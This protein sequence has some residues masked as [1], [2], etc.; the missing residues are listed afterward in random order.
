MKPLLLSIALLFSMPAWARRSE[1]WDQ[2]E[3]AENSW[4]DGGGGS[5][6]IGIYIFIA[7]I[8]AIIWEYYSNKKDNE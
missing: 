8:L 1:V 7:I 4:R 6:G 3:M 5:G 2:R